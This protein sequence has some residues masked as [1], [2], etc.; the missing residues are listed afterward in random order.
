[1]A[2]SLDLTP[3]RLAIEEA[4]SP[5]R[6]AAPPSSPPPAAPPSTGRPPRS[7]QL[8]RVL[9]SS[10]A[11]G[12]S[13][14]Q[15]SALLT[16]KWR[17]KNQAVPSPMAGGHNAAAS[18][19]SSTPPPPPPPPPSL[20]IPP[21][22]G[23]PDPQAPP[24]L[25]L[26]PGSADSPGP[27]PEP[28][29]LGWQQQP[30][31]YRSPPRPSK[32]TPS[33]C[34][35]PP[36]VAPLPP[37]LAHWT[38]SEP[39]MMSSPQDEA[40]LARKMARGFGRPA[41]QQHGF[42]SPRA[43]AAPSPARQPAPW[44]PWK[45]TTQGICRDQRNRLYEDRQG[46]W[47]RITAQGD[48]IC[49][50]DLERELEE[51]DGDSLDLAASFD[52][53][54]GEDSLIAGFRRS[55]ESDAAGGLALAAVVEGPSPSPPPILPSPPVRESVPSTPDALPSPEEAAAAVWSA[56]AAAAAPPPPVVAKIL[57][58]DGA[59]LSAARAAAA[60]ARRA[61]HDRVQ[62]ARRKRDHGRAKADAQARLAQTGREAIEGFRNRSVFELSMEPQRPVTAGTSRAVAHAYLARVGH[63]AML[64]Y[65]GALDGQA[66]AALTSPV[67]P[68]GASAAGRSRDAETAAV[69]E[70]RTETRM[71]LT[72]GRAKMAAL[73]AMV[74]GGAGGA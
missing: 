18:S 20:V 19:W 57:S 56:A 31:S 26:P 49:P 11:A 58:D 22:G 74:G 4:T 63:A 39:T 12:P 65:G 62:A 5:E 32:G 24:A 15:D 27:D 43:A 61:A 3:L 28:S 8:R 16:R 14:P 7:P 72:R 25:V 41:S 35:T 52:R 69:M 17:R 13:S 70:L 40:L 34:E 38:G 50:E 47:V 6:A 48:L 60:A 71:M 30:P 59:R 23:A 44:L 9:L 1:M 36:L 64:V 2:H 53:S 37:H 29:D 68:T 33:S 21:L 67:M 54:L 66:A 10:G 51:E 45:R 55:V 42:A 46:Q 73:K